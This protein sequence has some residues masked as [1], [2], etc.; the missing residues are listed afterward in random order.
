MLPKPKNNIFAH[1]FKHYIFSQRMVPEKSS[2]WKRCGQKGWRLKNSTAFI[3]HSC[4]L[5]PS[6]LIQ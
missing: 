5:L 6:L 3:L 1:Y 4:I 2:V